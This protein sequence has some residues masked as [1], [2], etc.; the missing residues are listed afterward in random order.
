MQCC[1]ACSL[2][3]FSLFLLTETSSAL[4]ACDPLWQLPAIL[5]PGVSVVVSPLLSLIQDQVMALV[6]SFRIPAAFLSSQLTLAQTH[7]VM[8]ELRYA[9]ATPFPPGPCSPCFC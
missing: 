1:Y 2:S 5:S 3:L 7:T 9:P 4:P 8:R 6:H